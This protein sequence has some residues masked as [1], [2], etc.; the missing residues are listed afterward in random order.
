M[1]RTAAPGGVA[2]W[3]LFRVGLVALRWPFVVAALDP[4]EERVVEV[5]AEGGSL[6]ERTG[7]AAHDRE[8]LYAG[9]AAEVLR[10]RIP[11]APEL[12]RF[13]TYGSGQPGGLPR[14]RRRST[15]CSDQTIW[16]GS[17]CPSRSRPWE[18]CSGF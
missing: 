14:S 9:A 18:D 5:L 17:C 3:V 11:I 16:S 6:A 10:Q 4:S 13:M 7:A 1:K 12:L 8:E 15:A 2:T